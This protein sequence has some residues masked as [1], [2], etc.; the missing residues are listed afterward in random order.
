[1]DKTYVLAASIIVAAIIVA[2]SF[3]Y[4]PVKTTMKTLT[5]T[6]TVMRTLTKTVTITETVTATET[7]T[8]TTT[9]TTTTRFEKLEIVNAYAIDNESI[10]GWTVHIK[11]KN[12]GIVETV[13]D[14]VFINNKLYK[15]LS[16][17]IRPGE[18]KE[19]KLYLDNR[20][21]EH[22]QTISI[23]VHT[24]TGGQY[25]ATITLS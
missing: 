18:T 2:A 22:A 10:P 5:K 3:F 9:T 12:T 16:I 19:I 11:V 8:E 24:S 23:V 6:T 13:I 14:K 15:E 21:Y 7:K 4:S 25:P 20:H 17:E 1:M